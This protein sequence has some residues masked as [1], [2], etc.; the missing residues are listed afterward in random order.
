[1]L[2]PNQY[3]FLFLFT[4]LADPEPGSRSRNFDIPALAKSSGSTTLLG[5]D[6]D[7]V[8]SQ[9]LNSPLYFYCPLKFISNPQ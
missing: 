5:G 2:D 6:S 3:E 7:A 8:L 9:F 1:M 4:T